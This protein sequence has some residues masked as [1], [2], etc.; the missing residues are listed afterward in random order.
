M[1][2]SQASRLSDRQ[3]VWVARKNNGESFTKITDPTGHPATV[4]AAQFAETFASDV[5]NVT[6][7]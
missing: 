5:R 4:W 3:T 6:I 2:L 1:I 7:D